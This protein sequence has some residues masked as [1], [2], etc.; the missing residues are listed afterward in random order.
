[1]LA[2]IFRF[3]WRLRGSHYVFKLVFILLLLPVA[4]TNYR[5]SAQEVGVTNK[6]ITIGGVM[7]LEGDSRGLGLGMKAG[8]EAAIKG[9]SV[10]DH[11]IEFVTL[12]DSYTPDLT[13]Q[14]T[15]QL[16]GQGIF[17][18]V[19]NVGTPTAQVSLPILAE[20]GV[21]AVGFFTGA[22]LLR[23]GIGDVINYRASYAQEI[24]SL[25]HKALAVG[26]KPSEVCAMV[27][28]DAYGM[29][30]VAGL[31]AALMEDPDS[32]P[33]VAQLDDILNMQGDDPP[34]NGVGPVGVYKRN[35][36]YARDGYMSLK[37]WEEKSSVPC[38]LVVTVGTYVPVA[39]FIGYARFKKENWIFSAVSFTGADNFRQE[40]KKY[41]VTD[42]VI[43]TQVVPD[44]NAD[45]PIVKN[46]RNALGERLNYVSLEG[47]IVGRMFLHI[48]RNINGAITRPNFLAAVKGKSFDLE[49][50]KL[51]FTHDNQGSNLVTITYLQNAGYTVIDSTILGQILTQ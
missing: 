19:G 13:I 16:I 31:K 41:G 9:E 12:N 26:I 20:N 44:L 6:T 51:D 29:A 36:L 22:G 27:Q 43:M 33:T 23:P 50:L 4:I 45:L 34:R 38:R 39:N 49:G 37:Q 14:A 15:R 7:D 30:G 47:Y 10:K 42:K 21:P 25:I 8:I 32:G 40:L 5:I 28:N 48:M 18:M 17:A 46:A 11:T 24:A 1:M 3:L 2:S 35:T